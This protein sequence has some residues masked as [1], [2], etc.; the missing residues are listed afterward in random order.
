MFVAMLWTKENGVYELQFDLLRV[1]MLN[2]HL[3][4][5]TIHSHSVKNEMFISK[6][7]HNKDKTIDNV[8]IY[9]LT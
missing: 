4:G 6:Q 2:H 3:Q 8:M 5:V 1:S 9:L 7:R